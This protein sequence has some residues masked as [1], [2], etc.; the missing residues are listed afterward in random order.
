M[1][2]DF[3]IEVYRLNLPGN[4]GEMVYLY[5]FIPVGTTFNAFSRIPDFSFKGKLKPGHTLGIDAP[6]RSCTIKFR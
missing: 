5:R 1:T 4:F 3:F 6:V 2:Y